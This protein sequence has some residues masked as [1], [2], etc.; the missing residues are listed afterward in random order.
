MCADRIIDISYEDFERNSTYKVKNLH[1]IHINDPQSI[2]YGA[3]V[4]NILKLKANKRY[5]TIPPKK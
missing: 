5:P 4:G 1:K 2:W 3:N